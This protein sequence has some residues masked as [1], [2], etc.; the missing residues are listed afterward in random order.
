MQQDARRAQ[1]IDQRREKPTTHGAARWADLNDLDR[2]GYLETKVDPGRTLLTKVDSQFVSV[3]QRETYKHALVC[4]RTGVGKSSGFFIPNLIERLG[5][6][7]LVT[8]A[9][10]E[11]DELGE[12]YSLTAGWR[13]LAGHAIYS[14]NPADMTSTRIN[15]IDSVRYAPKRKMTG[16]AKK[17]AE[18][19][20]SAHGDTQRADKTWD[21]SEKQLLYPLILHA[22]ASPPDQGHFGYIRSLLMKGVDNIPGIIQNSPSALAVE[23]YWG[24]YNNTSENFRRGVAAG[25]VAKL[26]PWQTDEIMELTATT[27]LDLKVLEDQLFTIYLSVP[28]RDPDSKIVA[29][30]VFNYLL[31]ILLKLKK[32]MTRPLALFLD[33]F[34]NFGYIPGI[35]DVLSIVRKMEISL[36]LGFQNYSQLD[37]VYGSKKASIIIDQPGT[38]IYFRQKNFKEAKQLSDALGRTT[39]EERTVTDTGKVQE[40]IYGRNLMTPDE[41]IS[42]P[43][44]EVIVFTPDTGPLKVKKFAP[45]IY[46]H[47]TGYPPPEREENE[48]SDFIKNRHRSKK[49]DKIDD[50]PAPA[51]KAITPNENE[52]QS[53]SAKEVDT[54]EDPPRP[55]DERERDRAEKEPDIEEKQTP[56]GDDEW[57]L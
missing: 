19:I 36:V 3:P 10:P 54:R 32:R 48:I 25:L 47:A 11:E 53:T 35:Q 13:Q 29:A 37:E 55:Q 22:A 16:M 51:E 20:I 5:T 27:D 46:Q 23:E 18:L 38:Q 41:L 34:T 14:F 57:Q 33:E 49:T 28:V 50:S 52:T 44:D 21:L 6:N 26:T 4:G 7:M 40:H 39:V 43:M 8:E 17:I 45:G 15:P 12:L 31:D 9:I 2:A 1:V 30:L 24:W 42:L 56:Y